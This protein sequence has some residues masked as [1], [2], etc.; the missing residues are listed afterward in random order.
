[1]PNLKLVRIIDWDIVQDSMESYGGRHIL[2]QTLSKEVRTLM[3]TS[4]FI[5]INKGEFSGEWLFISI[6]HALTCV[7]CNT[8]ISTL[9]RFSDKD[10]L[11]SIHDAEGH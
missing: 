8:M 2:D 10:Y 6:R 4:V 5:E 1:M 11:V 7:S 9:S 3:S